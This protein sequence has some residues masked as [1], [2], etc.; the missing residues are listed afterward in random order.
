MGSAAGSPSSPSAA[1]Q[2]RRRGAGRP[3]A[4]CRT[5]AATSCGAPTRP[6][7]TAAPVLTRV[8]VRARAGRAARGRREEKVEAPATVTAT[9]RTSA[10]PDTGARAQR[11]G[12]AQA[13]PQQGLGGHPRRDADPPAVCR[14]AS[15]TA[16]AAWLLP[17]DAQRAHRHQPDPGEGSD[18]RRS[19]TGTFAGSC[20]RPRRYA[21]RA[22]VPASWI[23][24]ARQPPRPR[25]RM[26]E[27][28]PGTR[29]GRR[30]P[31]R[32]MATTAP[33]TCSQVGAARASRCA[34]A[35]PSPSSQEATASSMGR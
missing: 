25:V 1:T 21:A 31:S 18:S 33:R 16:S 34:R 5:R 26:E 17:D 11:R 2:V 10:S 28:P 29:P 32:I 27:R 35:L 30:G 20:S 8:R 9:S 14:T 19:R 24:A 7:A 13:H 12:H 4:V 22:R 3:A 6:S 15:R 23:P